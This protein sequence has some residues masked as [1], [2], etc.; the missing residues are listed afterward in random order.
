MDGVLPPHEPDIEYVKGLLELFLLLST[1]VVVEKITEVSESD[2]LLL[3][4]SVVKFCPLA[5]FYPQF[6]MDF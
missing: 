4:L 5:I 1:L 3:P 2:C 6:L